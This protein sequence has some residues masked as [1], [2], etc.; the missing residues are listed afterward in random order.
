M[1]LRSGSGVPFMID[2][3]TNKALISAPASTISAGVSPNTSYTDGSEDSREARGLVDQDTGLIHIRLPIAMTDPDGYKMGPNDLKNLVSVRNLF[4]FLVG[5]SLIA[6]PAY[7]TVYD[8][9]VQIGKHLEEFEFSNMDRSTFGE[10]PDSSFT[11]YVHELH[12][13]DMRNDAEKIIEGLLLGEKMRSALIWNEAFIHAAGMYDDLQ[14]LCPAKFALLPG[15]AIQRLERAKMDLEKRIHRIEY[16]LTDFDFPGVFAG[17]MNSKMAEERGVAGFEEWRNSYQAARR[18]F[19]SHVKSKFGSWPP[20]KDKK[21]SF[22]LPQLNRRVLKIVEA[23]I[24]ILYDLLV[25]RKHPSSRLVVRGKQVDLH[26][27]RRIEALRKVLRECDESGSP[28]YPTMPFDAPLLPHA[29]SGVK[30]DMKK[31]IGK[32]DLVTILNNSYNQDTK[33]SRNAFINQWMA[34]EMKS[35][36]GMTIDKVCNFRLGAWL[37]FYIVLQTLPM[38]TVD[39]PGSQFVENVDYFLCCPPRG[40]LPWSKE[41]TQTEWFRDPVT[42]TLTQMSK[43]AMELTT[44][45]TYRLSHCWKASEI[46]EQQLP[47]LTGAR[48]GSV[49]QPQEE[50]PL[51]PPQI[52]IEMP[53]QIGGNIMDGWSAKSSPVILPQI[54]VPSYPQHQN[55]YPTPPLGP[56]Y[57]KPFH[58]STPN[59][60]NLHT[61]PLQPIHEQHGSYPSPIITQ[62]WD[63]F[64]S[65]GTPLTASPHSFTQPYLLNVSE[66]SLLPPPIIT[67]TPRSRNSS[68]YS[69]LGRRGGGGRESILMGGLE[70]LP[71]PMPGPKTYQDRSSRAPSMTFED[72]F[73]TA[74]PK[75]APPMPRLPSRS[76]ESVKSTKTLESKHRGRVPSRSSMWV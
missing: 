66:P 74:E 19:L 51:P 1:S 55:S 9:F 70:R 10:T 63:Q 11:A 68:P 18:F 43:E 34:F 53:P 25:D 76:G 65:P 17:I 2:P 46:W 7:P 56:V 48:M 4:A 30:I 14:R 24:N 47:Q 26:H 22:T 62:G 67:A 39:A 44:E 61:P 64:K 45:A 13:L 6:T 71:V 54:Q 60:H 15:V 23:D 57:E 27:D 49:R 16:S 75:S 12:L 21:S 59:L 72:I 5:Q 42:G 20:K 40:R 32:V 8:V 41:S 38:L 28:V 29:S 52:Q 58:H 69:T 36:S 31:K 3:R 73:K 50:S 35:T 33:A 37:F